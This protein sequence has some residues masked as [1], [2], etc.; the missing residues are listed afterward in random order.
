MQHH[1]GIIRI[2]WNLMY[3]G[4]VLV[5]INEK[6]SKQK[7]AWNQYLVYPPCTAG[8]AA[9][10]HDMEPNLFWMS[11]CEKNSILLAYISKVCLLKLQDTDQKWDAD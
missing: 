6:F 2:K 11:A 8:S 9:I 3:K 10:Q 5:Q 1:E 4:L 7:K